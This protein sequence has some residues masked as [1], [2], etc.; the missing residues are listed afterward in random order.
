M[1]DQQSPK[2]KN[3]SPATV[4][5]LSNVSGA[6]SAPFWDGLLEVSGSLDTIRAVKSAIEALN[7]CGKNDEAFHLILALYD[8]AA[9]DIP[10]AI[11]ELEPYPDGIAIFMDEFLLDI[12]DLMSDYEYEEQRENE[13]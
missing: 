5:L 4:E 9:I 1:M 3:F 13:T 6:Y 11:S 8:L 10:N 7:A 2:N 12:E